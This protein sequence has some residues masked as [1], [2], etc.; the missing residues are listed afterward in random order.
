MRR[1]VDDLPLMDAEDAMHAPRQ[2][3]GQVSE[4]AEAAIAYKQVALAKLEMQPRHPGHIVGVQGTGDGLGEHP[5]ADVEQRQEMGDGE[6]A[7]VALSR[8]LAEVLLEFVWIIGVSS[9]FLGRP[10]SGPGL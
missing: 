5:R 6:A 10:A 2:Q 4:R 8:R 3:Q 9:F 7:A 1:E